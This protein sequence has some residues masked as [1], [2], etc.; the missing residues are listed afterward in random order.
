MHEYNEE[1]AVP[2]LGSR[3]EEAARSA[4]SVAELSRR[5][6]LSTSV[7]WKWIKGE[8]EPT[9]GKLLMIAGAAG[10]HPHWL[11]TGTGPKRPGGSDDE[12]AYINNLKVE[13]SDD[14]DGQVVNTRMA[15]RKDWL[16]MHGLAPEKLSFLTAKGDA[17]DPTIRPG[18]SLLVTVYFHNQGTAHKQDL[19]KGLAPGQRAG[20]EGIFVLKLDGGLVVKRL[21]P[22]LEGGYHVRSDNPRYEPIYKKADDLTIVGKVEWIGRRL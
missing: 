11:L 15:F 14:D 10:L 8:S 2:G 3:I 18:D 4:E 16:K 19:V 9:A 21:Q 7:L 1:R 22:D 20:Q 12:F 6:R 5:T 17:M 13:Y